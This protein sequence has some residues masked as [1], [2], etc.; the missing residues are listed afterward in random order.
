MNGHL[1]PRAGVAALLVIAV[2]FGSNHVAARI[3][4][5]H[6]TSVATAVT[7]RSGV[8]AAA[9]F[10]WLRAIG[11]PLALPRPQLA[12]ACLIGAL[13]ALQSF[14]LYSAV[15]RIP[16]ALA[17]LAF[18]TFPM[19]LALVSWASGG[20]RPAVRTLIAMPVALAGLALALDVTGKAGDL[21]GRWAEIGAGVAW[22]LG[23]AASFALVLLLTGR[24]LKEMDGRVRTFLT[25]G[26]TAVLVGIAGAAGDAFALPREAAG[27][28]GLAILTLF[29]GSAITALF[30]VLPRLGAANYAV[31]LNIEPI[32]V[33]FIA[34]AVLGQSVTAL[35]LLGALI[36]IGAITLPALK[37]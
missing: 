21:A 37:R 25:M 16:V 29:Y 13:V 8:T 20:E 14:C 6:G 11:V 2:V 17:L 12:R 23:A 10:L 19:L 22:A 36:V 35:Q 1:S 31:V 34:W 27:W 33:L 15:A 9:L 18:N 30:V 5:D 3:A 32:A 26:V 7:V 4:F 28:G 24:W